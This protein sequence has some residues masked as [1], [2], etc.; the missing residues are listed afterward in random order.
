MHTILL[1]QKIMSSVFIDSVFERFLH[2]KLNS[3]SYHFRAAANGSQM[4]YKLYRVIL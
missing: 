1:T 4:C 2:M 3:F